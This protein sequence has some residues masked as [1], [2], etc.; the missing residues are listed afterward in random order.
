[1]RIKTLVAAM[2]AVASLTPIAANA[3]A[4]EENP[5]MLRVRAA[6]LDWANG[7]TETVQAANVTARKQMIPEFDISYFFTKNIAAELVLT[8]P[9][10]V[11]IN[12]GSNSIGTV[13]AL[14]PSL[15]LQYHF[16]DFGAFKPYVGVGVNYTIFGNRNNLWLGGNQYQVDSSSL[17]AVGQVG[18]DYMLDK[19]WGLNL[20]VKYI[21]MNTNVSS[22]A[23]GASV[24]K[25][26]L[27]PW[28]PAVGVTYKF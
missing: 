3:Q 20:D 12:A 23:T 14:P 10:T 9:Q 16:T 22:V 13:K 8:Y 1:M 15:V 2:A 17:G 21:S 11:T 7:Q 5:W 4:S 6:Y 25:L 26:N 18:M 28:T 24:G 27:S 19:N